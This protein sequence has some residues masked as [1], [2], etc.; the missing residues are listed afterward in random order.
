MDRYRADK[1]D[2]Y[3]SKEMNLIRLNTFKERKKTSSNNN[4]K[5]KNKRKLMQLLRI[6]KGWKE[7]KLCKGAKRSIMMTIEE[8][9]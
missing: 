8:E 7:T 4:L 6:I 9:H 2:K 1:V 3:F 5:P